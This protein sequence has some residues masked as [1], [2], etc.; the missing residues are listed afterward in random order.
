M[1]SPRT[2][3]LTGFEPFAGMDHNPSWDVVAELSEAAGRGALRAQE[4]HGDVTVRTALLPVEF[5]VSA[6]LLL[7]QM[8]V[9]APDL[10]ISV[11]LAAGTEAVRLERVGLN[12]RD[13]RIPDNAGHQPTEEPVVPGGPPALFATL[14]LKA[15]HAAISG[16]GI[17]VALSLS[18]GSFVCNSLLYTLLHAA[19]ASVPA[20]FLHVPDLSRAG[21][22]VSRA[23]AARAVD[24]LITESLHQGPDLQV[25]AGLLH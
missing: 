11:G 18:A 14:R 8:A 9:A 3:L 5:H 21:S 1:N 22:P 12:L 20:G 24:L 10:V 2:V 6:E 7:E 17:P 16:A 13:A 4:V 23:Q 19:P 15:A 25:P